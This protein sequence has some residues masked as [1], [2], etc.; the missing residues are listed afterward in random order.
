MGIVNAGQLAVYDDCPGSCASRGGRRPQPPRRCD[1]RCSTSPIATKGDGS[2]G[3]P[4]DLSGASSRWKRLE[5]ALVK[6][7][8]DFIEEDARRRG[9]RPSAPSRSSRARSWTA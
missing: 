8:T 3:A 7:I 6:G 4:E 9:S 1:E 5:H 2:N